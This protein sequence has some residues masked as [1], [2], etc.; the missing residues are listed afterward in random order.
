MNVNKKI[1]EMKKIKEKYE[2]V[3]M[4]MREKMK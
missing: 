1:N 2:I 3:I 4:D